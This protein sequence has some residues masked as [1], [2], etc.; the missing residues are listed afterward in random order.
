MLAGMHGGSKAPISHTMSLIV[1]EK[2]LK[3]GCVLVTS[4]ISYGIVV[5]KSILQL[6]PCM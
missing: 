5:R 3:M 1:G 4:I 6:H 2:I